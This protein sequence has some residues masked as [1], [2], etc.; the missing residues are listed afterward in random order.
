M[1]KVYSRVSLVIGALLL[2]GLGACE[3]P[4]GPMGPKGDTGPAGPQGI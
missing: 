1:K 4:Q 3:G 2:L